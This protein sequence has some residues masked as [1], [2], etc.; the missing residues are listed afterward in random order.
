[1]KSVYACS[2]L[3]IRSPFPLVGEI[4]ADDE[5][6]VD[7]EVGERRKVPWQ[8]PS[9][10]VVAER[11]VDGYPWYT[12]ARVGDEL[13]CRFCGR[14]DFAVS[15][16]LRH[17]TCHV[18]PEVE[19]ELIPILLAGTVAAF[20][21][22]AAGQCVL[23]AS[24]VEIEGRA[25]AFVG[26]SGQGKTTLATLLCAEGSRLV[27]DDLLPIE[28]VEGEGGPVRCRPTGH[29][30]RLRERAAALAER[31]AGGEARGLTADERQ[32]VAPLR[33]EAASLPLGAIAFP[34]PDRGADRAIAERLAPGEALLE[35]TRCQ[36]IEGWTDRERIRSQFRVLSGI[37]GHVP[38]MRLVVPW[39]PP[40]ATDIGRAC[41]DALDDASSGAASDLVEYSA[42]TA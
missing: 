9:T 39:G 1:M 37:V 13:V 42:S 38:V 12:I 8:R 29:E 11:I 34:V 26:Q 18:D 41:L 19:L 14:V 33:T 28:L 16:D 20:L 31:F 17:V 25:L 32:A 35:L 5:W 40:F 30:L 21:Q 7:V 6:D 4:V 27:A 24:A 2:G 10:D 3:R 15:Q 36:R 23:H 22:A